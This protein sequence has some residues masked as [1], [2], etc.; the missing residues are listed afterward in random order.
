MKIL[1]FMFDFSIYK[2]NKNNH[3][4]IFIILNYLLK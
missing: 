2:I 4:Y 1:K 3:L